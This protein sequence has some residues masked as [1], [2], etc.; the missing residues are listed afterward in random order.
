MANKETENRKYFEL[1]THDWSVENVRKFDF[2]VY[3][4]LK[5]DGLALYNLRVVPE[6]KKYD[7]FIAMPEE[8]GRDK[9][10]YKQY[11][12]YLSKKDTKKVIEA[13]ERASK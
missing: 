4:T 7:A 13:V 9:K 1:N 2:G 5:L 3:F 11:S 10:Y 8:L 6:G 12:I